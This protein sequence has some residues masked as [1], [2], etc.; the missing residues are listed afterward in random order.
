[1]D[2]DVTYSAMSMEQRVPTKTCASS[3]RR[4]R[5]QPNLQPRAPV[6]NM[7]QDHPLDCCQSNELRVQALE[8]RL[9]AAT[10]HP[11]SASIPCY[12]RSILHPGLLV[13]AFRYSPL[14]WDSMRERRIR[15]AVM[16]P[17]VRL[18][19]GHSPTLFERFTDDP[20]TL[21]RPIDVE[22][23]GDTF[24]RLCFLYGH[25]GRAQC[26]RLLRGHLRRYCCPGLMGWVF[27]LS[28]V[29]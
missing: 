3:S 4:T 20:Q 21:P 5:S 15:G 24:W 2:S 10:R 23:Y 29:A 28:N 6:S 26:I 22:G 1:M 11:P 27:S 17:D 8:D 14:Q 13:S 19:L 18:N 12:L 25:P 7:N 9:G 16:K